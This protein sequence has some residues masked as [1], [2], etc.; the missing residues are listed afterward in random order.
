MKNKYGFAIEDGNAARS[1]MRRAIIERAKIEKT[2]TYSDLCERVE[3]V[4]LDPHSY[5]VAACWRADEYRA[6]GTS[7]AECHRCVQ[8]RRHAAGT[9]A[10]ESDGMGRDTSGQGAILVEM[11]ASTVVRWAV[12]DRLSDTQRESTRTT[13][14]VTS[15]RRKRGL[16]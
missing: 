14:A 15:R 12:A 3:A 6:S 9:R 13:S 1:E 16:L 11:E 10:F 8:V 2:I 5:A 4:R 7:D